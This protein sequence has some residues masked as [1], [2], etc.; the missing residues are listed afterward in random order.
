MFASWG[1][2]SCFSGMVTATPPSGSSR[3][4][5]S[6]SLSVFTFSGSMMAFTFSRLKAVL[7]ISGESE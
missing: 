7:C 6:M 3:T 4:T 1:S 2:T 5:V